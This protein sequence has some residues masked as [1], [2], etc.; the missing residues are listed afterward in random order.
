MKTN[1]VGNDY[2]VDIDNSWNERS[3]HC[4]SR[5]LSFLASAKKKLNPAA[6]F[7][8]GFWSKLQNTFSEMNELNATIC[9][10]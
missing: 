9:V 7:E 10:I 1:S 5:Q 6:S 4:Q 8:S 3:K 2:V